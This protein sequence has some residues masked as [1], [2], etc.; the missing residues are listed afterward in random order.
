MMQHK[1]NLRI[2]ALIK[3]FTKVPNASY[4][5]KLQR[6]KNQ[7]GTLSISRRSNHR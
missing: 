4:V 5:E 1:G 2:H 7:F 3:T 6:P